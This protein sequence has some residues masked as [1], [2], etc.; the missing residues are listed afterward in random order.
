MSKSTEPVVDVEGVAAKNNKVDLGKVL[1]ATQ[2]ID[3][4]RELG[5]ADRGFAL[6]PPFQRQVGTTSPGPGV[7]QD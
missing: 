3:K 1:K 7:K 4:L 6:A 5:I 2:A